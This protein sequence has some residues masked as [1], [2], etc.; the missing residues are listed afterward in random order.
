MPLDTN[1]NLAPRQWGPGTPSTRGPPVLS[2][3]SEQS[4]SKATLLCVAISRSATNVVYCF[5]GMG[6]VPIGG[7]SVSR[8]W[9]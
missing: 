3:I 8:F 9:S 1:G 5:F 7:V 4:A 2:S 6:A